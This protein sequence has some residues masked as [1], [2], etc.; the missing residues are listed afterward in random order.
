M[1]SSARKDLVV[2]GCLTD[3]VG[4]LK[5]LIASALITSAT[6]VEKLFDRRA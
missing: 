5:K 6:G 2:L 1:T 4:G 3:M